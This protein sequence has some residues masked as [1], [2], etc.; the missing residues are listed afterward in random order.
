[1]ELLTFK[2][3]HQWLRD[4]ITGD[5]KW[6]MYATYTRKRQWLGAGE[7]GVPT[8]KLTYTHRRPW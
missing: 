5:E 1:M 7:A 8:P 3:T 6:V 2:R 4:L